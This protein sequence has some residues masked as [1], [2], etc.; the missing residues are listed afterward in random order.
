MI[1]LQLSDAG[2]ENEEELR[3]FYTYTIGHTFQANGIDA[4][5]EIPSE[6]RHQIKTLN[7]DSDDL[8][9]AR[10]EGRIVGTIACG[11]QNKSVNKNIPESL[12]NIPEIKGVYV[13]PDFQGKGI[14][15]ILWKS[16]ITRF[17]K[18][19]IKRA[20]LDSGYRISQNFWAKLLGEPSIFM[21][22]YWGEGEHQKIWFFS[23][24]NQYK[25]LL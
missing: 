3:A 21:K 23:V 17:H 1:D 16:M 8:I 12:R 13:H 14:G 19:H 10:Y 6:V 24:D 9:I 7:R 18:R 2:P 11:Q 22:D 25:R 15:S 20:C 4:P 5:D